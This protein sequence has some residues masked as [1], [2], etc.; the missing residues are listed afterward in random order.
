MAHPYKDIRI[1]G[2]IAAVFLVNGCTQFIEGDQAWPGV[3]AGT[4]SSAPDFT[5]PVAGGQFGQ[6]T[7][8]DVLQ[9]THGYRGEDLSDGSS[10]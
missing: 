9:N 1:F 7:P 2:L 6:R 8:A 3:S 10:R 5:A 4:T